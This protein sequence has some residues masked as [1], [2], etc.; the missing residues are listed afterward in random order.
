[1]VLV[2][3]SKGAPS[4]PKDREPHRA[5]HCPF[6]PWTTGSTFGL[7]YLGTSTGACCSKC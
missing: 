6:S 1:M 3:F 4:W 5:R 7:I 2:S